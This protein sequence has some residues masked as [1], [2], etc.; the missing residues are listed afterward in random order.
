MSDQEPH[1]ERPGHYSKALAVREPWNNSEAF[2]EKMLRGEE[3]HFSGNVVHAATILSEISR[4]IQI[5]TEELQ[6]HGL[7]YDGPMLAISVG[8]DT[9]G[10]IA[11]DNK[12]G[13]AVITK[14]FLRELA[15]LNPD[16][17]Y[18]IKRADGYVAY[19]GTVRHYAR[20]LGVEEAHHKA[21]EQ[22]KGELDQYIDPLSMSGAAYD[23]QDHEFR[24][25]LMQLRVAK[26]QDFPTMS[27]DALETRKNNATVARIVQSI[28][29]IFD[30]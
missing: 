24:A 16:E 15:E 11:V 27:L 12:N 20:L 29:Q 4:G 21:F 13:A 28:Q 8:T 3:V 2:W 6:S 1:G 26:K 22:Y 18:E 14:Q 30:G 19:R 23:A 25:L 7:A 10:S 5:V 17:T 9:H